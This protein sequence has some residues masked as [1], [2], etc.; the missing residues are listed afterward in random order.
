MGRITFEFSSIRLIIYSLF[1]KQS[2]LS[3]TCLYKKNKPCFKIKLSFLQLYYKTC[4]TAKMCQRLPPI[5]LVS[6]CTLRLVI[7]LNHLVAKQEVSTKWCNLL[8][9]V[10]PRLELAARVFFS[11]S[12]LVH[13]NVYVLCGWLT[14]YV[15]AGLLNE[16]GLHR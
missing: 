6:H 10:F 11:P 3:A 5:T 9:P 7:G 14:S 15:L 16:S 13:F 8:T 2:A 1:Q 4:R 12:L